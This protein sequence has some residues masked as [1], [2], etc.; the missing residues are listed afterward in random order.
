MI[1]MMY[2]VYT[3]LLALNVSVAV[4]DSFLTINEALETTNESYVQKN[5]DLYQR[6]LATY[7]VNEAKVGKHW[8]KAQKVQAATKEL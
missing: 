5:A 1:G 3:A 8:A 7:V 2:L 4:L 6:F